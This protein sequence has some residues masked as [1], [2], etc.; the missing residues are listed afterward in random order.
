MFAWLCASRRVRCVGVE[1]RDCRARRDDPVL[2]WNRHAFNAF[3][4]GTGSPAAPAP[5]SSLV[6]GRAAAMA[7]AAV[8]DAVDGVERRFSELHVVPAA[9]RRASERA[10]AIQAAYGVLVKLFPG[11]QADLDAKLIASLTA[12]TSSASAEHSQAIADGRAWGKRSLIRSS[13][14]ETVTVH[15]PSAAVS[16]LSWRARQ[17]EPDPAGL[18]AWR[19]P[20]VC[21]DDAVGDPVFFAVSVLAP[22]PTGARQHGLCRRLQRGQG[23]WAPSALRPRGRDCVLLERQHRGVPRSHCHPGVRRT[24]RATRPSWTGRPFRRA[25]AS[26]RSSLVGFSDGPLTV[27]RPPRTRPRTP[28]SDCGPSRRSGFVAKSTGITSSSVG[29]RPRLRDGRPFVRAKRLLARR[30][31]LC[32]GLAGR[33]RELTRWNTCVTAA[34][35]ARDRQ[36]HRCA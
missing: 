22:R 18:F 24:Q 13:A 6:T 8:F 29:L 15:G 26:V 3:R 17:M 16:W 12:L 28:A 11:Q 10:A 25:R 23:V 32:G 20:A 5:I 33:N 35:Y 19:G 21:H 36:R 31:Q 4:V 2:E 30:P 1:R 27:V 7:Q 34:T 9:P 14:G